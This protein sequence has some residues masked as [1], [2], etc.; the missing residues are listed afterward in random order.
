MQIY[1]KYSLTK[2]THKNILRLD[3]LKI[4]CK[5]TNVTFQTFRLQNKLMRCNY[6]FFNCIREN[7][8]KLI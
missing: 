8:S 4:V 5:P 3:F 2:V 7:I 6:K 1:G